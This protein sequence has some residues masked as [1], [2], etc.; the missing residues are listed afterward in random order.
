MYHLG[1]RL[2]AK[3]A[4]RTEKRYEALNSLTW[5]YYTEGMH[6]EPSVV[7]VLKEINGR[8]LVTGKLHPRYADLK[9]DG[10][11]SCGCWIYCGIH[12]EEEVNKANGRSPVDYLGH[13]WAF[14]W[15]ND[16]RILYNRASARP[17][18]KPWSERKKLIWWDEEKQH[19]TGLDVPDF[20]VKKRPDYR[21]PK[22]ARGLDGI[23]GDKPFI[24]HADGMAWL[25]VAT[26][27]KDGPL[28]THYE[29][30]ESLFHNPLYSGRDTNPPVDKKERPDN[31]YAAFGDERYP[32][33]TT[34]YRLTEHHT[35][36][37]MS[38]MLSHL[39]ELQP[40]FF[41]EVSPELAAERELEHGGYA[42]ISTPRGVIEARVLVTRR[43][44]PLW[45]AGR[46]VH[47]VGLP[48]HWGYEG[49]VK[50]DSTNDLLA[51]SEEPNVRIMETKALLCDIEP[52]R[53]PRGE[54]RDVKVREKAEQP[55]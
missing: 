20:D 21:P 43:M 47:Q 51:I 5:D 30:L 41:C 31:R 11:T 45:V 33:V 53:R 22:G 35:A 10:T 50:G 23:A 49:L 52:G 28:P 48:Y 46:T 14:S 25:W 4:G 12:P 55:A 32:F 17:D 44:K 39:A 2:K 1:K 15:P 38:R 40:E 36:G 18:G 26:G 54:Q 24:L 16:I 3:A 8:N 29:P 42:T 27:L 9:D 7:D 6:H 13:G 19:W 37:G 34:T